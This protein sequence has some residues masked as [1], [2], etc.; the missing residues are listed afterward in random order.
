M[1]FV[2]VWKSQKDGKR[3]IGLINNL[4]KRLLQYNSGKVKSTKNRS[5]FNLIY[6]EEFEDRSDA[7]KR[8]KFFKSGKGREFLNKIL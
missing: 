2:Y 7:A 4:V 8:E 5:P 3:Y 6:F 1:N